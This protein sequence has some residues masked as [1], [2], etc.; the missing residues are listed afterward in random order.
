LGVSD[1]AAVRHRPAGLNEGWQ[2]KRA[3]DHHVGDTHSLK[4]A[5]PWVWPAQ[6]RFCVSSH[7]M[8]FPNTLAVTDRLA[9]LKQS[10]R[11]AQ[12]F[13][14]RLEGLKVEVLDLI[15]ADLCSE[16]ICAV[17]EDSLTHFGHVL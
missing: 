5:D 12:V 4:T 10:T 17:T 8:C 2:C 15:A 6:E 13:E 7:L 9:Q 3:S 1:Q 11:Q 16:Q 14:M